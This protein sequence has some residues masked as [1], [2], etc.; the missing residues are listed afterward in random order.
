M[1]PFCKRLCFGLAVTL[2]AGLG[3]VN[4]LPDVQIDMKVSSL[5]PHINPPTV[6]GVRP[7]TPLNWTPAVSG[8]RPVH[9]SATGLPKSLLC[10]PN[11]ASITGVCSVPGTYHVALKVWNR[12]GKDTC[13]VAIV[14]GKNSALT[15]PMGWNSYDAYGDQVDETQV[16]ANAEY[17]AKFMQRVGW[18]TI[19]VDYR[20]YDPNAPAKRD[21]GEPGEIL[22][23]DP[24][25]R[26]MPAP[27]RFP[28]ASNG[29]GFQALA[30]RLHR[31][32]LK[33]GIHIMRGI[34]RTAVAQNLPIEGSPFHAADAANQTDL[35][36]WCPDMY[37]VRGDTPAGRAYYDSLFRLYAKWGVDYV[38]MDDTSAPYHTD[39]IDAVHDAIQKSG[40]TIVYSLSPGE[41]PIED[42]QHVMTHAN[43]W[44]ASGDFW[45]S[46][47]ALSHEFDL[48]RKW[49]DFV[50]P[51]H[52]AD[53]DMLPLGH[54]S[55]GGRPV[56][57]DRRT[58]F[59]QN[60]Q[61]TLLS[62]WSLLP[63]PLMV[64]ANLPDNDPWT[65]ALLTNPE[66]IAIDQDAMGN[67]G[68]TV[69][70]DSDA[71][72]WKKKLAD[73]SLAVGLFNK[74]NVDQSISVTWSE[75]GLSE[76][77]RVRDIWQRRN[78]GTSQKE[79]SAIVPSHGAVLIRLIPGH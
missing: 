9:C 6:V 35:C 54:I 57:A 37:G 51:G 29:S 77:Q 22:E 68:E 12:F 28:S 11:T 63:S 45:D 53:A 24:F 8:S 43:L 62:L 75:L 7:G 60:E 49:H 15:P 73:G 32:G 36:P 59:T 58:N 41:T 18:D 61:V 1:I 42:A 34:P 76:P 67:A 47:R 25:G 21:N 72:V 52:W 23:M 5:T 39:E 55:L 70:H 46:W 78:I 14:V 56:G 27:N 17:V 71:E 48:A 10:D 19:V 26:L 20:W 66:V 13:T 74:M 79:Y 2:L 65:L 30:A 69:R 64:G 38:K 40:R 44:R 50:G 3:P 4:A 31:M 16:M 33:F